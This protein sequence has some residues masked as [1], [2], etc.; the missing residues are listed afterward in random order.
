MNQPEAPTAPLASLED[1]VVL[2]RKLNH[3]VR[4]PMSVIMAT[5][6]MLIE[7]T[8]GDLSPKQ[9]RA[10]ER[11]RRSSTHMITI[12][13]HFILYVKATANQITPAPDD[14]VVRDFVET[15][16][17]PVRA[18]LDEQGI[19]LHVK[20]DEDVPCTIQADRNLWQKM[21][22]ALCWNAVAFTE[23]GT[24]TLEIAVE[25]PGTL[26]I[27]VRDTG[28]GIAPDIQAQLFTPF[29]KG[30]SPLVSVPT[31]GSGLG[32][33]MARALAELHDGQLTL[34]KTGADGSHFRLVLP[35][36]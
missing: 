23:T 16:Q 5:N 2:V 12:L 1:V 7:G 22:E 11:V 20:I 31:A 17:K 3:D 35:H 19:A 30:V 32:L 36:N 18:L 15:I 13:D 4:N 9:L 6:D 33:A 21:I 28:K 24:I 25:Q 14:L 27:D 8:Y 29:C 26:R 34:I 10:A